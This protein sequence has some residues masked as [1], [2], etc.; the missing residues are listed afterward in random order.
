MTKSGL[1]HKILSY[2]DP[3]M[4]K[5]AVDFNVEAYGVRWRDGSK[6]TPKAIV[7]VE[8]KNKAGHSIPDG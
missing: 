1:G 5:M 8:M 7:R 6:L 2:S 4:Q 3:T